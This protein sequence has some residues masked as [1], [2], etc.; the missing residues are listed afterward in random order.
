MEQQRAHQARLEAENAELRQ[1]VD[2]LERQHDARLQ[3]LELR[4]ARLEASVRALLLAAQQQQARGGPGQALMMAAAAMPEAAPAATLGLDGLEREILLGICSFL[5]PRDLGR[6]ACVSRLFGRCCADDDDDGA[7]GAVTEAGAGQAVVDEAAR[8]WLA[9]CTEQER[10]WV[11]RRGRKSWL[12]QMWEVQSLRRGAV[13]GRSHESITLSEGGALAT[14]S[15]TDWHTDWHTAAS[16]AAMRAGRHYAQFTMMEGE[17]DLFFGVIRPGW[18][19]EG[20]EDAADVDGHCFYY[21]GNGL[22]YPGRLG[23]EGARNWAIVMQ[24]A[25]QGDRIGML[26]DLDQGS[27]TVYKNDERLGVMATGLSGEYC[28]AVEIIC[29]LGCSARIESA[30]TPASK[31]VEEMTQVKAYA[32]AAAEERRIVSFLPLAGDDY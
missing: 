9:T 17:D 7:S 8:R 30:A 27:M 25:K 1:R 16:K 2:A 24:G 4:N 10:G 31:P 32:A 15:N 21:T 20:G 26:L 28:W 19:V 18:D 23:W 5:A 14:V 13:L 22:R 12:A 11:P 6:L 3:A 29:E